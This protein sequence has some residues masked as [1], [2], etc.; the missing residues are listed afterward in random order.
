MVNKIEI[1]GEKVL[2]RELTQEQG[3]GLII[4]LKQDDNFKKGIVV[5]KANNSTD[6]VVKVLDTVLFNKSKGSKLKLNDEELILF[7]IQDLEAVIK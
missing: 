4:K 7:N 1:F 5:Q 2:V 3:S 6:N